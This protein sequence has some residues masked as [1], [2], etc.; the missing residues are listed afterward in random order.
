ML[1]AA[2]LKNQI[3]KR[4]LNLHEFRSQNL[5][6]AYGVP[7]PKGFLVEDSKDSLK[8][9][10]KLFTENSS[11]DKVVL[12]SQLLSGGRGKG[13][14]K[15][16]PL[17]SGIQFITKNELD[18][19]NGIAAD[20]INKTLVTKQTG[21]E[22]KKVSY[23]YLTEC[24][25]DITQESYLSI[26]MDRNSQQ[27]LIVASDQGGMNIE[28]VAEKNPEK[29]FKYYIPIDTKNLSE[30]KAL[31]VS[32]NLGF[33]GEEHIKDGAKVIQNL[34]KL[35]QE[36]DTSLIEINP[37]V[38]IANKDIKCIDAK[39]SFDDAAEFRQKEVFSW[40]D[41][42]QEDPDEVEAAKVGLNYVKLHG[43]I[44]TLVNG[45]GLAMATMDTLKLFN[46]TPA[47]F[48]D[49]GGTATPE[50]IETA[51][52]LILKNPEVKTILVNI[53]GGIV[54]CDYV[55]EGLVNASKNLNISIPIVVRLKGTNVELGKEILNKSGMNFHFVEE[56]DKAAEK[57]VS[58]TK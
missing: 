45:A 4:F 17:T 33:K 52:R 18:K 16:S 41:L 54:R 31:E 57:A 8:L 53:F 27:I 56:F 3:A 20:M 39:F 38:Q 50:T 46:G 13:H 58:F 10:E 14:F 42:T 11:L 32:K 47:N 5:M 40:R 23:V 55:A 7:V 36:K 30:E 19:I 26:I 35:F 44:A 51:F 9:A 37:I 43:N 34:F 6:K 48:L 22:G 29:I 1:K 12:K 15:D 21:A 24:L 2:S 49:C 25:K 28:E